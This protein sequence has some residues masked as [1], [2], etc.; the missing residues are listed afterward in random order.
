MTD[1]L[2]IE[3]IDDKF[4]EKVYTQNYSLKNV[5]DDV[6]IVN[7]HSFVGEDGDFSEIMRLDHNGSLQLFPHFKL[8]QINR[9]RLLSKSIKAWHLH[10]KQ[11]EI[12]YVPPEGRLLVGLL[13]LR[14]KSKTKGQTMRITLGGVNS[15]LLFIPKGVAHGSANLLDNVTA[16][17]YFVD[18]I[19]NRQNP[20]EKRINWDVLGSDFW[21]PLRD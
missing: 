2:T 4:R 11:N 13:D 14:N 8:A 7:V 3:D 5:I 17:I 18:H 6:K 15:Q 10:F 12:W 1:E 21:L 9:S 20:D 16:V 19:F